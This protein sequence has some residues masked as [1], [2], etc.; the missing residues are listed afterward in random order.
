VVT[1]FDIIDIISNLSDHMP[2]IVK[3]LVNSTVVNS[4]GGK[5]H[6]SRSVKRLRWDRDYLLT[7]YT[8]TGQ[9]LQSIF[10]ELLCVEQEGFQCCDLKLLD[11]MYERIVAV[12]LSSASG[13]IASCSQ[14]FFK[15]WWCE[16]L[17]CLKQQSVES[18]QLLKAAG[19]P[20]SGPIFDRRNKARRVYRLGI[21]NYHRGP[22]EF[23][24]NDLHE[25][26]INK[27][28]STFGSVGTRSLRVAPHVSG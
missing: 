16:E 8:N 12:L 19:R 27:K 28:G 14:N 17:D 5:C 26:L 15:F 9:Q 25:A 21:R 22:T 1:D 13:S 7:Y 18:D 11:E 20:R 2:I 23:Y 24:N 10:Y 4:I 6:N 3:C